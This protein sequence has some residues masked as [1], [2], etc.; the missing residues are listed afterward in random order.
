LQNAELGGE[1]EDGDAG[2]G[3]GGVEVGE[4]LL[5]DVKLISCGSVQGVEEQEI[6]GS[7]NGRGREVGEDAG[8]KFGQH[9][10]PGGVS[11]SEGGVFFEVL[12]CLRGVLFGEGEVG[13]FESVDRLLIFVGDDDVDYD[14]LGGGAEGGD[15]FGWL[16]GGALC[17]RWGLC[18][19]RSLCRGQSGEGEGD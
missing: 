16:R 3:W 5:A 18:R 17:R 4:K 10:E 14:E 13:G 6:D 7:I 12:D 1:A 9:G 19:R 15:R 8:R 11:G 2:S